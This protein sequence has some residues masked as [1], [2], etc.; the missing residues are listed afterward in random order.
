MQY[1]T[2]GSTTIEVSLLGLG[3][4]KLGRNEQMKYPRAF[5]LPDDAAARELL[6]CAAGLGINLLDTA[7]AY[8]SSE[9]RLGT[10]LRGR[11]HDWILCTKV[12]EE[13]EHGASWFDFSA[14]HVRA[15]VERSL[16]RLQ[17]DYL[18]L[19]LIHSDGADLDILDHG[20]ALDTLMTLKQAG[21]I[22]AVG[23]SPKTAA[24]G[25]RAL[26]LGCDLIMA[27]L[28][29]ED[30][31]QSALIVEAGELGRGVLVKKAL[32]SGH[33]G[34]D[35]LRFVVAHPGVTSM[36]VGTLDPGHLRADAAAL[37]QL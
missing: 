10:L 36:V 32:A 11:R 28:N 33:A 1:R 3:T 27:T 9:T 25:R 22:R 4:V 13:F 18:D 17:S 21:W 26:A 8:G 23:M 12:G 34:V 24:G 37:E 19:V 16:E 7:P 31:S 15:S 5:D 14:G 2:L 30:R 20:D 29:L 6:D 35:S